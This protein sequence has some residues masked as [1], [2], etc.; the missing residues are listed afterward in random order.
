MWYF[1]DAF[2]Y[3]ALA[4]ASGYT[5][6]YLRTWS[7]HRRTYSLECAVSD[8]ETKLLVE[9]KRRAGQERQKDSRIE[10]EIL[11]SAKSH[12][13]APKLPWWAGEVKNG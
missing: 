7:L 10:A 3:A 1:S 8:L 6:G 12:P 2:L 4:L 13:S 9:V 11:A 5:A